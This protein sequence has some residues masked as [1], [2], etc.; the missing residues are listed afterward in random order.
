MPKAKK[1]PSGNWRALAYS[2]TEK[3][4][5][6]DG[7]TK[8]VRRYESFTAPTKKEAEYLA[9]QF[10]AYNKK[11]ANNS[12]P[13]GQAIDK[14]IQSKN[15]ILSPSTIREY[16]RIRKK[17]LQNIMQFIPDN[18]SNIVIQNAI[19]KEA[20]TH[21]SKTV[22]NIYGLLSATFKMFYPDIEL[23]ITLPQKTVPQT[24]IPSNE[25][26]HQ[27][28]LAA[29]DKEIEIPIMLSAFGSLRRSEISALDSSDFYQNKVIISKA[30]VK[31]HDNNWIIK[32][33]KTDAGYRVAVLPDF[34]MKKIQNIK[35][36]ITHLNPNQ[37]S[38]QFSKLLLKNHLPHFK[39][40][41][42]RHYFAST[43]HALNVPNK[44][45]MELGGWSSTSVLQK[46]Y[47]HTTLEKNAEIEKSISNYFDK[48][49]NIQ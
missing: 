10:R 21:S 48:I 16:M 19:N 35:G 37:I 45:V 43:L 49:G 46:I 41:S 13:I 22:K 44:Y 15:A 9:A 29:Q 34:V 3:V 26:L 20:Q 12:L 14:Y 25:E 24:V 39:F 32:A 30:M 23:K 38:D 6:P 1:L 2:H 47:Q 5:Q 27:I 31:S 11:T 4:L 8:N 7:S 33:P 36:P 17:N 18:S 40:H 42:L 28:L